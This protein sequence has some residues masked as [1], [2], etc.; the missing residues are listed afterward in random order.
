[1]TETTGVPQPVDRKQLALEEILGRI[2]PRV[3]TIMNVA[4]NPRDID[5]LRNEMGEL[6]NRVDELAVLFASEPEIQ[7][8]IRAIGQLGGGAVSMAPGVH[9]LV[10]EKFREATEAL[11]RVLAELQTESA[12]S[13]D[14]QVV[15]SNT[16]G[17]SATIVEASGTAV[18]AT[19]KANIFH[20]EGEYWTVAYEGKI[21][22]LKDTKGLRYIAYLLQHPERSF[23]GTALIDAVE[24]PQRRATQGSY[25]QIDEKQAMDM[26]LR[27]SDLGHATE[28][29]NSEALEEIK[30]RIKDLKERLEMAEECQDMDRAATIRE[31]IHTMSSCLAKAV[32]VGGR[33]RKSG[34]PVEKARK[35]V[36]NCIDYSLRKI[37]ES[38]PS[39]WKHLRNSI[40]RG[41]FFSYLPEEPASWLV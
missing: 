34:D 13:S 40:K 9:Q 2:A 14:I 19:E 35:S 24:K 3:L 12:K 20:R 41:T 37:K 39:L 26:G 4:C 11:N 32:G 33:I 1:M 10:F 7:K 23:L 17:E 27:V 36:S 15:S 21:I 16:T 29:M 25:M 18:G 5:A 30:S 6:H 28:W 8:H 22:R 38:H 31:E